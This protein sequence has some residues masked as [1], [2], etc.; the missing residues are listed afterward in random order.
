M[1]NILEQSEELL[2]TIGP[3]TI[4]SVETKFETPSKNINISLPAGNSLGR[5][6]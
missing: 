3:L 2:K 5:S 4:D 1:K 6:K